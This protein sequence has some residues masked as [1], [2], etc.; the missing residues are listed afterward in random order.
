LAVLLA[1]SVALAAVRSLSTRTSSTAATAA[2]AGAGSGGNQ[3]WGHR[4]GVSRTRQGAR[5]GV[6]LKLGWLV[7][8]LQSVHDSLST[9][10]KKPAHCT[11]ALAALH[12]FSVCA[13]V[14]G[15]ADS[16]AV[17]SSRG[18]VASRSSSGHMNS[19]ARG[20]SARGSRRMAA[21]IAASPFV[22]LCTQGGVGAQ[23]CLS[24]SRADTST[25]S[26]WNSWMRWLELAHPAPPLC[27]VPS[28]ALSLGVEETHLPPATAMAA[29]G[30]RT[31]AAAAAAAA[32]AMLPSVHTGGEGVTVACALLGRSL[33]LLLSTLFAPLPVAA[34]PQRFSSSSARAATEGFVHGGGG[35]A[36]AA[37]GESASTVLQLLLALARKCGAFQTSWG[38]G[39]GSA[40]AAPPPV[41]HCG[42]V[43]QHALLDTVRTSLG[44]LHSVECAQSLWLS[45]IAPVVL[46][47][48]M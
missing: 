31:P 47:D 33:P 28:A 2:G 9:P 21:G 46:S 37:T 38:P 41:C 6:S 11:G 45:A 17:H 39:G 10:L 36:T 27:F 14:W 1:H 32:A 42:S 18:G 23:G 12:I 25:A 5:G 35:N 4:G 29:A 16:G 20:S 3:G 26:S 8:C 30:T 40:S 7:A 19:N 43:A 34:V 15:N 13:L 22:V 48:C 24:A 44:Q